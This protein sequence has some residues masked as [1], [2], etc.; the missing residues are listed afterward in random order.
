MNIGSAEPVNPGASFNDAPLLE[1][2]QTY[3]GEL[4]TGETTFF[5]CP[6]ISGSAC[7]RR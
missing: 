7:R 2:G 5:R 6:S 4:L 3:S 1:P